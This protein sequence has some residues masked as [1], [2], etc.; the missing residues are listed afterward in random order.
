MVGKVIEGTVFLVA[1][2]LVVANA[3]NF[4]TVVNSVGGQY[5]NAVKVLQARG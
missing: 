5:A 2:Y 3:G 1:L 4:S